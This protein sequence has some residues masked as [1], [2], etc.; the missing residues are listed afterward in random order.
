MQEFLRPKFLVALW[1]PVLNN[2]RRLGYQFQAVRQAGA[3][4]GQRNLSTHL[5]YAE[6]KTVFDAF[7]PPHPSPLPQLGRGNGFLP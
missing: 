6:A 3:Y 5:K 4:N 2:L 7:N 1:K